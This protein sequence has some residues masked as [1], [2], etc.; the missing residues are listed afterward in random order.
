MEMTDNIGC[1]SP[2][3]FAIYYVFA[4][5]FE[6]KWCQ[7]CIRNKKKML[8]KTLVFATHLAPK[9]SAISIK[10]QDVLH[11][12][13]VYLASKRTVFCTKTQKIGIKSGV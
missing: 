11:Q 10:T 1:F 6:E 8:V 3:L 7:I 2:Q 4:F 13:A 9:R 12:N 5:L